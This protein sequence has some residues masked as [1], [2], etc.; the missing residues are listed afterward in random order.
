MN[1]VFH[2]LV[3][4]VVLQVATVKAVECPPESL[5]PNSEACL[6]GIAIAG[7]QRIALFSGGGT[8]ISIEAGGEIGGWRVVKVD[9]QEV[10]IQRSARRLRLRVAMTIPATEPQTAQQPGTSARDVSPR[11]AGKAKSIGVSGKQDVFSIS[12]H[13]PP[14]RDY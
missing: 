14:V 2:G 1:A 13:L 12:T 7:E 6:T 9:A 3:C 10:R 11:N 5:I 8:S 4:A